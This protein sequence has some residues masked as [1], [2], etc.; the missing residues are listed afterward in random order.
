MA[1]PRLD[2]LPARLGTD[3]DGNPTLLGAQLLS[4]YPGPLD[5][6]GIQ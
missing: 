1:N 6:R 3:A 5:L 2:A 4:L